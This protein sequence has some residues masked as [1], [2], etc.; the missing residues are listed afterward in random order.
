MQLIKVWPSRKYAR[1]TLVLDKA[2]TK[3]IAKI[4]S[5]TIFIV[6]Y[7]Q[8][9]AQVAV[10]LWIVANWTKSPPVFVFKV[11][12]IEELQKSFVKYPL[13]ENK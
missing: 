7:D 13:V 6:I 11:N 8:E 10:I 2:R 1:D 9:K 4:S 12:P 3:T 5:K